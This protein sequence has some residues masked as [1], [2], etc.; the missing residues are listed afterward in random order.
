MTTILNSAAVGALVRET[1][2]AAGLTQTQLADRIGASRFWV[3]AFEKGKPG[4]ELGLALKAILAL[5][6]AINISPTQESLA[7]T[8]PDN[9]TVKETRPTQSL[10][11]NATLASVIA[12]A[13]LTYAAPSQVVGWPGV[14][15]T[16]GAPKPKTP[17]RK[18]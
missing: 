13:T 4:A 11:A 16:S 15:T 10:A 9:T 8:P 5:G 2:E 12:H 1:R 3:A 17:R 14:A 7:G 18:S 6:L